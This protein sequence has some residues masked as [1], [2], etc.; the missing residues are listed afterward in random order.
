MLFFFKGLENLG[1]YIF[2]I[3]NVPHKTEFA[4]GD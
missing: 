4:A 1:C 3:D 2:F